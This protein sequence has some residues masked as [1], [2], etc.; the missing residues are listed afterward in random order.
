MKK[1]FLS[2]LG[3]CILS[4]SASAQWVAQPI[5]F[6]PGLTSSYLDAIDANAAWCLGA[7]LFSTSYVAS[8]VAHTTNAGQSWTVSN[9]PAP[10]GNLAFATS[11]AASDANTAW[12]TLK[13]INSPSLIFR[14]TDGGLN[15]TPQSSATVYGDVDSYPDLIY[16]FSASEGLTVGDPLKPL[17][18]LEMYRTTDGGTTWT[19]VLNL[20]VTLQDE[21]PAAS[22][23][24]VIGNNIWFATSV[25]RIFHSADKGLTWT[26]VTVDPTLNHATTVVFRD[27]LSGLLCAGDDTSTAHQLYKT[28]DGGATWSPVSY[29]GPLHGL[30]LSAV[31][32]TGLYVSG[33]VDLGNGDQG[34]SY[35]RDNGLTW[36]A[37]ENTY[38]HFITEFVS[39]TVGW[40]ASFNSN[41]PVTGV[42]RFSG[43]LLANRAD[44]AL[45]AGL[46]AAPNPATG[47]RFALQA[48]H[49]TGNRA[50]TVRV[51]D[52]TGRLVQELAWASATPLD[53]DLSRQPAGLYVLEVQ[54]ASG[55]ARQKVVVQ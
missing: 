22:P 50:A 32:G 39:A 24:A 7:P 53:L 14:T 18:P 3:G 10:G 51:L 42:N 46:T 52:S 8:Q 21:F 54:S 41:S 40:S 28:T 45:Q 44:V 48:A 35:S 2:T 47:G 17:D 29:T 5:G 20:P 55:T 43:T 15:W 26:A 9:L 33:G 25:G 11:L 37:L 36:I 31:P 19:P 30:G 38:D 12:I 6:T 27:A 4:L 16:M 23:P 13:G 49:S 34:S 1:I